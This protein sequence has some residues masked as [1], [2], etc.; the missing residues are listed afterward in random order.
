MNISTYVFNRSIPYPSQRL[1][2]STAQNF[3]IQRYK[4]RVTTADFIIYY[5]NVDKL[6]TKYKILH[7]IYYDFLKLKCCI[8]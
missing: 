8:L 1:F 3:T 4:E 7:A 6:L 5:N 2:C